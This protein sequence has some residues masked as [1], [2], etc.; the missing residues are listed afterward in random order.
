MS[1]PLKIDSRFRDRSLPENSNP[2]EFTIPLEVAKNWRAENRRVAAVQP[3]NRNYV[4]N[5]VHSVKL[6]SL[7]IPQDLGDVG[8]SADI[9]LP[10]LHVTLQPIIQ[11]VDKN[12]VNFTAN[13]RVVE[14][15]PS[16][17]GSSTVR[18]NFK[19]AV[20][21][22]YYDKKIGDNWVLYKCDQ[23]QTYRLDLNN[24]IYF[25]ITMPDG[26]VLPITDNTYPDAIDKSRQVFALFESTPYYRES[27]YDNHFS[28][29][30]PS[31]Y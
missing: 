31:N 15:T 27:D 18:A 30:Y 2:A 29:L 5:M 8:A 25:K 12:L 19:D 21:V 14:D 3:P 17:F 10:F 23:I 9:N 28:T 13:G 11:N 7:I 4:Q 6:L 26:Q 20:F 22:P 24:S 16:I 1:I